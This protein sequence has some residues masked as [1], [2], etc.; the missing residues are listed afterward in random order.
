[1]NKCTGNTLKDKNKGGVYVHLNKVSD[2]TFY[3]RVIHIR[4]DRRLGAQMAY[5][6][7]E[8][9][10]KVRLCGP[11]NISHEMIGSLFDVLKSN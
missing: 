9:E 8:N 3:H 11:G 7:I 10:E 2:S 4:I 6:G 1:M 5:I